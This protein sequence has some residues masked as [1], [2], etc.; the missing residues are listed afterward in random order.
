MNNNFILKVKTYWYFKK[1]RNIN[2]I[3]RGGCL[4]WVYSVY[5]KLLYEWYNIDDLYILQLSRFTD[6]IKNNSWF[7][8]GVI[9]QAVAGNHFVIWIWNSLFDSDWIF[10]IPKPFNKKLKIY[11]K[12][13]DRFCISALKSKTWNEAFNRIDSIPKIAKKL[14]IAIEIF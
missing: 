14:W 3:N 11:P 2:N 5:K 7:L 10:T 4:Y 12:D 9:N 13:I 6:D 1:I 8:G